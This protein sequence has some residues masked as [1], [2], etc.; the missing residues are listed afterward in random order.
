MINL[1]GIHTARYANHIAERNI[2]G[3]A[4]RTLLVVFRWVY[5]SMD[6]SNPKFDRR[7]DGSSSSSISLCA[8]DTYW[9]LYFNG[10]L[11]YTRKLERYFI[12]VISADSMISQAQQEPPPMAT[13]TVPVRKKNMTI[14][15]WTYGSF[16]FNAP[17]GIPKRKTFGGA[18][19]SMIVHVS[20]REKELF[21]WFGVEPSEVWLLYQSMH[22]GAIFLLSYETILAKLWNR[23][24]TDF[25]RYGE[26]TGL[27]PYIFLHDFVY[28]DG[29]SQNVS[30]VVLVKK[31]INPH[32]LMPS[33]HFWISWLL[34]SF[35]HRTLFP[36]KH[37]LK[38]KEYFSKV[39]CLKE[40]SINHQKITKIKWKWIHHIIK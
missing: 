30:H 39:Y 17:N 13:P 27:M 19:H 4:F 10:K 29:I 37:S 18:V 32:W 21:G 5:F 24:N 40:E 36:S 22:R 23:K 26:Q 8:I 31:F 14:L 25:L 16:S 7:P 12:G 2:T 33:W 1:G 3:S 34:L 9:N 6:N 35:V 11:T 15:Q 28:I 20:K 38:A